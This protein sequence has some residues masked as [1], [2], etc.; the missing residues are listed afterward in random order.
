M[1]DFSHRMRILFWFFFA[2]VILMSSI[3]AAQTLPVPKAVT[4]PKQITSKPNA[5][6]EQFQQS[7]AIEKLYMTRQIGPA[8]WSPDGRQ[9][10]FVAIISGRNNLW[11]VGHAGGWPPPLT[12]SGVGAA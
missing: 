11:L 2:I 5:N 6:V 8:S 4:D 12:V 3:A 7:L 9:V 10:V 1:L